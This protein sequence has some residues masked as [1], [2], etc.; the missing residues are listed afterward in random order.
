MRALQTGLDSPL[1]PMPVDI[2]ARTANGS[3]L[4][5]IE[6]SLSPPQL[7]KDS[8]LCWPLLDGGMNGIMSLT[9][10][11]PDRA[12]LDLAALDRAAQPRETVPLRLNCI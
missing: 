9:W 1:S 8:S 3:W 7:R 6:Q 4:T 11:S 2:S 12:L 5:L 10:S